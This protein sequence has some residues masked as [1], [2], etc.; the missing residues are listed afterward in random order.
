MNT[1]GLQNARITS[2]LKTTRGCSG[3]G[4]RRGN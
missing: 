3:L 1:P 2:L 4:M